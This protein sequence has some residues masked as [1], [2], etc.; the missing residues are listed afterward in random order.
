MQAARSS[1]SVMMLILGVALIAVTCAGFAF[2]RD[3]KVA[4]ENVSDQMDV[5]NEETFNILLALESRRAGRPELV[6]FA[7]RSLIRSGCT[8]L[9]RRDCES[10]PCPQLFPLVARLGSRQAA[11]SA[12]WYGSRSAGVISRNQAGWPIKSAIL[13]AR[14]SEWGVAP[15]SRHLDIRGCSFPGLRCPEPGR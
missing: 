2:G 14:R 12:G 7:G 11:G 1:Q 10:T 3:A 15:Q 13:Q 8:N 5:L 6:A 9:A 4:P